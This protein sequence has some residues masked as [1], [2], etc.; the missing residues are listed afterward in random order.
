M[1]E[2]LGAYFSAVQIRARSLFVRKRTKPSQT[3]N[4]SLLSSVEADFAYASGN[5]EDF[6]GAYKAHLLSL[7]ADDLA[8]VQ[9]TAFQRLAEYMHGR[10]GIGTEDLERALRGQANLEELILGSAGKRKNNVKPPPNAATFRTS[11]S[12]GGI[13][14]KHLDDLPANVRNADCGLPR[15]VVHLMALI[16]ERGQ[17]TSGLFR[18]DG[19]R[20]VVDALAE[21]IAGGYE[22][23]P[24]TFGDAAVG[25][26]ELC[27]L[28]KRYLREI[29]GY[30]VPRAHVHALYAL[31]HVTDGRERSTLSRLILLTLP[32]SSVRALAAVSLFLSSL[33]ECSAS[34]Q[35]TASSLAVVFTPTLFAVDGGMDDLQELAWITGLWADVIGGSSGSA[36]K[37]IGRGPQQSVFGLGIEWQVECLK[38]WQ[39]HYQSLHP[40][41]STARESGMKQAS[42][43]KTGSSNRS[44]EPIAVME[45]NRSAKHFAR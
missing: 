6:P 37:S 16:V 15:V 10:F 29:E 8:L 35:M 44:K 3:S 13:F 25:V 34:T 39:A 18:I 28:L 9:A 36:G 20:Q 45:A 27:S 43:S 31:R 24:A 11:I 32:A 7:D 26:H 42:T 21:M 17:L 23:N 22:S 38:A 4:S 19:R 2:Q 14:G 12:A 5:D 40:L 33:A 1:P 30:L 41:P